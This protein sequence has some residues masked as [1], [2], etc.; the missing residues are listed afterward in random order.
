M[1]WSLLVSS[2]SRVKKFQMIKGRRRRAGWKIQALNRDNQD[3]DIKPPQ[4]AKARRERLVLITLCV[5]L[6]P[7]RL[8]YLC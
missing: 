1:S 4:G 6:R 5:P 7:L 2:D 8:N 3:W